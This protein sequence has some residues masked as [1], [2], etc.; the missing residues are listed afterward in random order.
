LLDAVGFDPAKDRLWFVGDLVNRGPGS[1]SVLR[2]V[3]RLGAAVTAV[4]GNHDLHLLARALAVRDPE[5][6]DRLMATLE[7]H[8]RDELLDWLAR[9]PLLHREGHHVLVHAGLPPQWSVSKA[10]RLAAELE[11]ALRQDPRGTLALLGR[12]SPSR[13]KKRLAPA[14]RLRFIARAL[15]RIRFVD[16]RG[17]LAT[18]YKGPPETAPAGHIPWFDA[19]E[20]RSAEATI[21]CGH[22]AALGFRMRADVI[23]LDSGC[24]WGGPLTAV[25]LEDRAVFQEPLADRL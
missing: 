20:R 14:D 2:S 11:E 6:D 21:V 17:R 10:A 13:W 22:W 3:R 15:T 24:V 23:A 9:R 12:K 7:A 19:P 16:T 25:R 18:A 5:P 1:L 4:L 8:D